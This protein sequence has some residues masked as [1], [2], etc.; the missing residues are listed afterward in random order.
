[1]AKLIKDDSEPRII[2]PAFSLWRIGLVGIIL[3]ICYWGLVA[4]L[5][6]YISSIDSSSGIATIVVATIGV[7]VML[8]LRMAQP[9]II[10]I[11]T[12]LTLWGLALWTEGLAWGEIIAWSVLLYA[13]AFILYSWIAHFNKVIPVIIS[14]III[15]TVIRISVAL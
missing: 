15:I 10:A 13:L 5:T 4:F 11:A 8:R 9:M 2:N 14:M 12:S 7:I 3:G 6:I 1:M